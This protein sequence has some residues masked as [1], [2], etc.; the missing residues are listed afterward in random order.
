MKLVDTILKPLSCTP[1]QA[2]MDN[3]MQLFDVME[4][5]LKQTGPSMV[6]VSTF[7]TSE[8]FL[9]KMFR[10][11]KDGLVRRAILLTDLKASKKTVNLYRFIASVFNEVYLGENHSKVILIMN[12]KWYVSIVTSQNQTRGNRFESGI[13]TTDIA[14]FKTLHESLSKQIETKSIHINALLQRRTETD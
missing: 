3:R 11:K 1:L 8:E 5:V 7:S 10:F 4:Y 13:I 2:Y 6:Y 14:I 12:E 9:R